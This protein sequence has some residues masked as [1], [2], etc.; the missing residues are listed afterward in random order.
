MNH[1][2]KKQKLEQEI[3]R[4]ISS[5]RGQSLLEYV[6]ILGMLVVGFNVL[7]LIVA[8]DKGGT[9]MI[10][11]LFTDKINLISFVLSMPF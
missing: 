8:G 6:I 1:L 2:N 5:Q 11:K 9:D 10:I 4:K 3:K 7:I